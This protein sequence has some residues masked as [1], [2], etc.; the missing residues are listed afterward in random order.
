M[1]VEIQRLV[2]WDATDAESCE[3][4]GCTR[5]C[6]EA[7]LLAE[8]PRLEAAVEACHRQGGVEEEALGCIAGGE[9]GIGLL[10]VVTELV[11]MEVPPCNGCKG[12]SQQETEARRRI[13]RTA[14]DNPG[15][16]GAVVEERR[17]VAASALS[18]SRALVPRS[19]STRDT[20]P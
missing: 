10:E 20:C 1:I 9:D 8:A 15:E 13:V 4:G 16:G 19:S 2:L 5:A 7:S 17:A 18:S 14:E 11:D 6:S 3:K 12:V